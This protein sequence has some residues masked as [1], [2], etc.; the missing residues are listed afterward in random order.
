MS[1]DDMPTATRT[2]RA[3]RRTSDERCVDLHRLAILYVRGRNQQ[4][5]ARQLNLSR[6][7]IVADLKVVRESW[8][9]D[10]AGGDQQ[11]RALSLAKVDHLEHVAWDAWDRSCLGPECTKTVASRGAQPR[12]E[13][14]KKDNVGNPRFLDRVAWCIQKRCALLGLD[15][16]DNAASRSGLNVLTDAELD[17]Q[18]QQRGLRSPRWSQ[19]LAT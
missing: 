11:I 9:S 7:Q 4:E 15:A 16:I 14:T 17:E 10:D 5:M 13:R 8:L 18:A 2:R 19:E 3:R 6:R 12:V 1:T